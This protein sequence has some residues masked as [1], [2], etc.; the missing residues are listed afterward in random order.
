MRTV[1][2]RHVRDRAAFGLKWR[3]VGLLACGLL[4]ACASAS[5]TTQAT[6]TSVPGTVGIGTPTPVPQSGPFNVIFSVKYALN[7]CG[8]ATPTGTLCLATS[9]TGPGVN[10]G[11]SLGKV[12]VQRTAEYAPGDGSTCSQATTAG[13]LTMASGDLVTFTGTGTFCRATQTGSFTYTIT[14]GTGRYQHASGAGR[15]YVPPPSSATDDTE[16]WS[17]TLLT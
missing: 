9:G 1:V 10:D 13:T 6:A 8:P 17:G 14:G 4:A 16:T 11:Q 15:F 5:S 12:T 7:G 3:L 2:A